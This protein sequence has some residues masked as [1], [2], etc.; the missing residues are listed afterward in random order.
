[1][2]WIHYLIVSKGSKGGLG[3]VSDWASTVSMT[4]WSLMGG[5]SWTLVINN[6]TTHQ[7]RI[8]PEV[9]VCVCVCVWNTI[10]H[11]FL[12]LF[13]CL[14]A[15]LPVCL[16]VCLLEQHPPSS[17]NFNWTAIWTNSKAFAISVWTLRSYIHP[18]KRHCPITTRP[19]D[20]APPPQHQA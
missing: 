2:W 10:P 3:N 14:L 6:V 17:P 7:C 18:Q 11:N 20:H 4:T 15:C 19:P 1:M 9:T 16:S 12:P 8:Y 5:L 13:V